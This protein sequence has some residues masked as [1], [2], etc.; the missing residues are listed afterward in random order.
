MYLHEG[1]FLNL[2]GK[3]VPLAHKKERRVL[4]GPGLT[5]VIVCIV[6]RVLNT[7]WLD[8]LNPAVKVSKSAGWISPGLLTLSVFCA[9][10]F[11]QGLDYTRVGSI[12]RW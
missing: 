3:E 12:F 10:G 6:C 7:L 8:F 2:C 11:G 9:G 4:G 5:A 1:A